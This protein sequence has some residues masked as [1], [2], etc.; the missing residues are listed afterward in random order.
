MKKDAVI[1]NEGNKQVVN[2]HSVGFALPNN[3]VPQKEPE[4]STLEKN[5]RDGQHTGTTKK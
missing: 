2:D 5:E 1:K 4:K 3:G